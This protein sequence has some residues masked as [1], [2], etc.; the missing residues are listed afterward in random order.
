[1]YIHVGINKY[2][3]FHLQKLSLEFV[4]GRNLA[5]SS[6]PPTAEQAEVQNKGKEFTQILPSLVHL[7]LYHKPS[8]LYP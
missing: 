8:V 7:T 5:L 6:I 4:L 1:M 2:K 3:E